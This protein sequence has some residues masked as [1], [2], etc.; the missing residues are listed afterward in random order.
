MSAVLTP[1]QFETLVRAY[2]WKRA[3]QHPESPHWY[4]LRERCRD[5][6]EFAE[7]LGERVALFLENAQ[8]YGPDRRLKPEWR[9]HDFAEPA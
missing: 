8:I 2:N 3:R 6:L 5:E 7:E 1:D 9:Q 4:L